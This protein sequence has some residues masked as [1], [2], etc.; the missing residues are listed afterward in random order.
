VSSDDGSETLEADRPK[1]GRVGRRVGIALFWLLL[2]YLI[3]MSSISIIPS[4]FYP[5]AGPR[6]RRLQV[7]A[8]AGEIEALERDL[9]NR[10]ADYVREPRADSTTHSLAAWDARFLALAGGCGPLEDARKDLATLRIEVQ[11]LLGNYRQGPLQIRMRIRQALRSLS[12]RAR[13][14]ASKSLPEG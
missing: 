8:C 4:L 1:A 11:R 3:G 7:Q 6:P 13:G 12:H 2:A 5:E 10:V 14:P 9:M